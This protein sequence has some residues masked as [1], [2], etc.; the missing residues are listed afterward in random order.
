MRSTFKVLF[1]VNGSKE[2]D[3]IVPIMGRITING[4]VAQFS[5]KRTIPKTLWDA[6]GNRIKGKSKEA[7]ETNYA[8]ENI[9]AQIIKHYQRISDREAFVSAEMVRNAFQGI[10]TEYEMLMR[11]FD[12]EVADFSKRVGKDRS[13]RTYRKYK[14]VRNHVAAFLMSHYRRKDI[15][16]NELTEEFI[17]DFALYL[18]NEAGLS[19][20]SIWIYLM[21]LKHLVTTAHYNGKI[22]RN[23]F[24]QFHVS[25]NIREREFLT[26][27]EL[28]I[29]INHRFTKPHLSLARDIFVF[30]CLT[31][32]SFIDIKNLTTENIVEIGGNKWIVAKRQKTGI[33]YQ[34]RLLDIPLMIIEKYK[35]LKG[36]NRLLPIGCNSVINR[37]LKLIMKECGIEKHIS[38]HAGRHSFAVCALSNGMPIESVSRILGHTN[39]TTTQIYA[40]ITDAKLDRDIASFADKISGKISYVQ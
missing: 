23:P 7:I 18:S 12:K 22:A 15:S 6:K 21:P 30:S 16:M 26:D 36:D 31:G 2:K 38:F 35:T 29:V 13:D 33:P 27:D 9:K 8:L 40:K 24:A 10:G 28:N 11:A 25:P 1:Y 3:G 20:S 32:I 39:I 5:C 34:I 19:Q 37:N 4:S 17:R 14:T